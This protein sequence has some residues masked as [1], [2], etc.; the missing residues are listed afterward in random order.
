MPLDL[1]ITL[2]PHK[3]HDDVIKYKHFPRYWPICAG[4]SSAAGEFPLQRPVTRSFDVFFDLRMN[5]R[6]SIQSRRRWLETPSRHLWR[7]CNVNM[8][9]IVDNQGH[10]V[11]WGHD[12]DSIICCW[13]NHCNDARINKWNIN[14]THNSST[15]YKLILEYLWSDRIGWELDFLDAGKFV[16]PSKNKS[17]N[18]HQYFW[19]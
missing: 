10:S 14:N 8:Q 12:A 18:R 5:K 3:F 9:A 16:C 15:A 11:N 6:L 1:N 13:K 7:H 17:R 4:N 2:G 19:I